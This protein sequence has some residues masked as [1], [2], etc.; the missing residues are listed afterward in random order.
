MATIDFIVKNGLQALNGN[1]TVANG[2]LNLSGNTIQNYTEFANG[3]VTI[4]S[5]TAVSIPANTNIVRYVLATATSTLT[6]PAGSTVPTNGLKN[7]LVYVKQDATGSRTIAFANQAGDTL[8]YN[9]SLTLPQPATTANVVSMYSC[10]KFDGD[11]NWYISLS[12]L[13]AN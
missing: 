2:N 8:R 9:N 3:S 13:G 10:Q 4:S 1:I 12:Y 6:L 5:A 7:I 11:S